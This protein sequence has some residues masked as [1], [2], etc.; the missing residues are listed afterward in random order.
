MGLA[1]NYFDLGGDSIL[2]L[3]VI[4]LARAAGL[5]L[6]VADLFRA[7]RLGELAARA[8]TAPSDEPGP[9][10]PFAQL[11]PD[12]VAA[13]PAELADAYPLTLLQAGMLHEM[14]ADPERGAYHNVT[15]LKITVPEG[16]D[17]GAFQ[18][19]VDVVVAAHD[20][21]RT[22]IDLVGYRE[23]LQLVHRSAAMP[24]GYTDLRGL[25]DAE[26]RAER[27]RY[28]DAQFADRFDLS[29]A[30][31]V[32]LHLHQLTDHDLRIVITDCHVALDGWSLTSMIAD[33]LALHRQPEA[34][35]PPAPRFADYVALERAA[36]DSEESLA[37]WR[38]AVRDLRPVR[39]PRRT[40]VPRDLPAVH[41]VRRS[42]LGL[43]EEIGALATRAGVPRRTVLLAALHH[44]LGLF[45]DQEPG[46]LGH[47]I[48]LTTNGRPETTGADH[49]RG[50][51]VNTVPFG[52][53]GTATSWLD[54]LGAV[55][56]AEQDL[57]PHRRVPLAKIARLAPGRAE[58]GGRGVQLRELPPAHGG[59]LGGGRRDRPHH[60]P[61]VRQ[62]ER[63]RLH[64]RRRP[65]P[66][67]PGH[68]R[69]TR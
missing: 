32:R 30:P 68:R 41:E 62:H 34:G 56:S 24:V 38:A 53:T 7:P 19:A 51:F 48:G 57:M 6:S 37:F 55:F 60:V 11:H 42:F 36:V 27:R 67:R 4:G 8:A 35:L 10:A 40:G 39:F 59:L 46:A 23:P 5:G 49:M 58:P 3:R 43:T 9:V 29:T 28:R 33:L 1:D 44:V 18:H 26:Q 45:A 69:A 65:R 47:A 50:L 21:L 13:L 17:R 61:P 22:S 31:L 25:S 54:L 15:D 64:H 12:D 14:L 52:L 66:P 63:G 2:A 16:F 20:I